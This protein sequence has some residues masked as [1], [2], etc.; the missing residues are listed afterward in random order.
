MDLDDQIAAAA[1]AE[2]EANAEHRAETDRAFLDLYDTAMAN[3][4]NHRSFAAAWGSTRQNI[5]QRV[6]DARNR[7]AARKQAAS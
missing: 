1:A 6:R 4:Y 3:G 2:R 5:I 7:Q